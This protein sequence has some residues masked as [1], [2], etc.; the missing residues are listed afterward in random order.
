VKTMKIGRY[1]IKTNVSPDG[2][3]EIT[4]EPI[5]RPLR[6]GRVAGVTTNFI[7]SVNLKGQLFDSAALRPCKGGANE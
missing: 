3:I 7:S 2:T 6:G 4:I 1:R 5:P